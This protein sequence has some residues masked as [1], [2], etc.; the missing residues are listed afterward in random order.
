MAYKHVIVVGIDGAGSFFREAETPVFDGIFQNGAVTYRALASNPTISA[1][2]WGAMLLGVGPKV[3]GLTNSIV[4]SKP[5]PHD[6]AYPSLFRRIREVMPDAELGSFCDWNPITYGIVEDNI[7][8]THDTDRDTELTPRITEYIKAKKPAFLF[9][10]MDSVDGAGHSFG[11]GSPEHLKRIGEVDVLIGD[12]YNAV[13]QTGIL[14]DT[15][16]CVIADHGGTPFN[17]KGAGHGGWTDVEKYVTFAAAGKTVSHCEIEEM[18]VRDLAAIVL[19]ALNIPA[20]EFCVDGW[21]SQIPGGM[22]SGSKIPS[23]RGLSAET[24]TE[25]VS[26]EAHTSQPV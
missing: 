17:G 3:H 11:Y 24:G 5:Y 16:F 2:C 7:S 1:E 18:N 6:S 26:K 25:Y 19:Y 9:V 22:F 12:I 21:T 14:D 20:P 13:R 8:V 15:L 4:S 23:Y 10:Q